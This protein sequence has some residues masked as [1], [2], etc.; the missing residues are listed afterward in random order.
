MSPQQRRKLG[1]AIDAYGMLA[2]VL[3]R[4][5]PD[6]GLPDDL[7]SPEATEAISRLDKI[8]FETVDGHHRTDEAIAQGA[9]EV[10]LVVIECSP[11]QAKVIALEMNRLHGDLDMAVVALDFADLSAAG[12]SHEEMLLSSFDQDEI[13]ALIK[14]LS[15]VDQSE[16]VMNGGAGGD[17]EPAEKP[18]R[19]FELTLAFKDAAIL[20]KINKA[21]GKL[22]GGG[23]KPDRSL[24][25]LRALGLEES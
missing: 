5:L 20:K 3:V 15:S 8:T 9:T 23:R 6:D 4:R 2:P 10:P 24:G 7:E 19:P 17:D 21:L 18:D 25:L 13:D 22:A 14:S 11:T 1:A 16:S 12:V